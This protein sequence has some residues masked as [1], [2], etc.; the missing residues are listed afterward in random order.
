MGIDMQTRGDPGG[1]FEGMKLGLFG[2]TQGALNGQ[3]EGQFL[4]NFGGKAQFSEVFCLLP[5]FFRGGEGIDLSL[6]HI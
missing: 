1:E 6:I 5:Y 2:K 3:G 4:D